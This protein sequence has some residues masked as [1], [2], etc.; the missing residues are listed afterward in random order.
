MGS[1]SDRGLG[2]EERGFIVMEVKGGKGDTAGKVE[3]GGTVP[4]GQA[5]LNIQLETSA[6]SDDGTH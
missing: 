3:G 1:L 6:L 2:S 5:G 4:V